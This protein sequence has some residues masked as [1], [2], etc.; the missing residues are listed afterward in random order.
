M[1]CAVVNSGV[2]SGAAAGGANG[3]AAVT[4]PA[5]ASPSPSGAI[6]RVS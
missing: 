5:D 3:A 2:A 4:D 1:I 6:N